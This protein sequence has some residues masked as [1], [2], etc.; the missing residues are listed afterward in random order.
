MTVISILAEELQANDVWLGEHA[1]LQVDEVTEM[2]GIFIPWGQS[3]TTSPEPMIAIVVRGVLTDENGK[4]FIGQ[5]TLQADQPLE[6][7]RG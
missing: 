1:T 4:R 2:N 7:R 6:V 5:W 3:K